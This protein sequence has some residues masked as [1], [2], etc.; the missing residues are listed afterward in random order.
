MA[1]FLFTKFLVCIMAHEI[2]STFYKKCEGMNFS[3]FDSPNTLGSKYFEKRQR[4]KC[5]LEMEKR[6][7]KSRSE[8]MVSVAFLRNTSGSGL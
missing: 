8:L 4:R 1:A 7:K 6:K 2:Y 5:N 3:F